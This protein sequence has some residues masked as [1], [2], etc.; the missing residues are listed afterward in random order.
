VA[1]GTVQTGYGNSLC[2]Y[3][4]YFRAEF[5]LSYADLLAE[6]TTELELAC[7]SGDEEPVMEEGAGEDSEQ[8]EIHSER[9]KEWEE[10]L[11]QSVALDA[12]LRQMLEHGLGQQKEEQERQPEKKPQEPDNDFELSGVLAETLEGRQKDC[13]QYTDY[14][15]NSEFLQ[16]NGG[17][18]SEYFSPSA[19]G[20]Q[21]IQ[22][23]LICLTCQTECDQK[24]QWK[25]TG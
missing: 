24:K 25:I 5:D 11:E 18:G 19:A 22:Q 16:Q 23:R 2:A 13:S 12:M 17:N 8:E 15:G 20:R 14:H 21:S 10:L 6:L 3:S 7:R 9:K 4:V 1:L